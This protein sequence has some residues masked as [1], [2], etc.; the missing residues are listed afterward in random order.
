[1]KCY[2]ALTKIPRAK[3]LAALVD[4]KEEIPSLLSD[5]HNT[6]SP[7]KSGLSQPEE[8]SQ[9]DQR[10][11][12]DRIIPLSGGSNRPQPQGT[13]LL[14]SRKPY[15]DVDDSSG[16]EGFFLKALPDL[17][18]GNKD[19][20]N[21][22]LFARATNILR[23]AFDVSFTVFFDIRVGNS[24]PVESDVVSGAAV[25]QKTDGR[26]NQ[27]AVTST[28]ITAV[29][30]DKPF[31][32]NANIPSPEQQWGNSAATADTTTEQDLKS[33]L[34]NVLSFSTE[35]SRFSQYGQSLNT[36]PLFHT[37]EQRRLRRLVKRYPNGKL[38]TFDDYGAE[39]TDEEG[40]FGNHLPTT[41]SG[42]LLSPRDQPREAQF[43]MSC[44]PGAKQVLLA[45]LWDAGRANHIAACFAVNLSPVSVF[46]T[47][48]EMA[49][50]KAFVNS[51]S[52][53]CSL[54]SSKAANRQKGDF[55]S[56]ISHELRSPLHG[57]IA[58]AGRSGH[59]RKRGLC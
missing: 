23:E 7:R 32:T 2:D 18:R 41:F 56:S 6:D 15:L 16:S 26:K 44:F 53:A 33:N 59:G 28:D 58:S 51:I 3:G 12:G 24:T 34:A 22:E 11:S 48:T 8:K 31:L 50:S 27:D 42:E 13:K 49:Y 9:L 37:P 35:T 29:T 19:S 17:S 5:T 20:G 52:V 4:G 47:D 25:Q 40:T 45:P 10:G 1:V 14:K 43:I 30:L 55:I 38:W 57:V 46:T 54:A 36:P 39:S 21:A